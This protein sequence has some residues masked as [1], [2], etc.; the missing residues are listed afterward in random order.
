MPGFR[1][2]WLKRCAQCG[3]KYKP[4]NP[5]PHERNKVPV[6]KRGKFI[7]L[8]SLTVCSGPQELREKV[9]IEEMEKAMMGGTEDQS[10]GFTSQNTPDLFKTPTRRAW[11]RR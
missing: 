9:M 8:C 1:G 7:P 2:H 11:R 5:E 6:D 4:R 10:L 3:R